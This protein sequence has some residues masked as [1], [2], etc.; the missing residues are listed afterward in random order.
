[1]QKTIINNESAAQLDQSRRSMANTSR[2]E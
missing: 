2:Q 1:M